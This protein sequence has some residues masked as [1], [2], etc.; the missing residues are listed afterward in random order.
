M[1]FTKRYVAEEITKKYLDE[2]NLK[3]LFTSKVDTFIFVDE[4]SSKVYELFKEGHNDSQIK[5]K[6]NIET[7]N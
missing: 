7:N 1:G 3:G 6:L 4:F 5:L 2:S